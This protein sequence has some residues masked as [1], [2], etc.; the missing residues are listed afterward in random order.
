MRVEGHGPAAAAPR[1][2]VTV[3]AVRSA[4]VVLTCNEVSLVLYA[5]LDPEVPTTMA[6][7]ESRRAEVSVG[8]VVSTVRGARLCDEVPFDALIAQTPSLVK[9]RVHPPSPSAS[10]V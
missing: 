2:Q 5:V 7:A 8:G 6:F 4:T 1:A 9:A 3:V 10:G